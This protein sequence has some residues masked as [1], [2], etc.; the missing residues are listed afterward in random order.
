M[1]STISPPGNRRSERRPGSIRLNSAGA[2]AQQEAITEGPWAHAR[3][4]PAPPP[5]ELA[6]RSHRSQGGG[7]RQRRDTRMDRPAPGPRCIRSALPAVQGGP[8]L[9][10]VRV[11][12]QERLRQPRPTR[13]RRSAIDAGGQRQSSS[14]GTAC[15]IGWQDPRLLRTSAVGLEGI[16][17]RRSHGSRKHGSLRPSLWVDARPGAR[18]LRGPHRDRCISRRRRRFSISQS[19]SSPS[20]TRSE[21]DR[22][23]GLHRGGR[24]QETRRP[25]RDL[26]APAISWRGSWPSAPR[27]RRPSAHR[28]PAALPD[29]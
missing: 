21:R 3:R 5:A 11:P 19:R 8:E 4:R 24:G 27:T 12:G 7:S 2:L 17:R 18:T 20:R 15:R 23:S 16:C 6:A 22:L 1:D 14:A 10:A 25:A 29:L 26:D 9:R 28:R 13:R